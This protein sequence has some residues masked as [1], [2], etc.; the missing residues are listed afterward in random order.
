[1]TPRPHPTGLLGCGQAARR[2]DGDVVVVT[3]G[4][5][6]IGLAVVERLL[7]DGWNVLAGD[8]ADPP[9]PNSPRPG[10]ENAQLDVADPEAVRRVATRLAEEER[11]VAG[12]VNVAGL[13]QDVTAL[14]AVDPALVE[15]IWSVNY[16]G[17]HRCMVEFARLMRDGGSIVNITSINAHRPLP[18][19]AYAPVKAALDAATRLA[20]GELGAAG[21]G[22]TRSHRGSPSPRRWRRRSRSA[23]GTP[24]RWRAQPLCSGSSTRPR[25]LPSLRS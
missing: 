25:S 4:T 21:S 15:R 7:D 12:L 18:L 14:D 9:H 24:R 6:G 10:L 23:P 2:T 11:G 22:S 17:A 3:G 13:L 5:G 1:M 19:H 8:V 20:A 16:L